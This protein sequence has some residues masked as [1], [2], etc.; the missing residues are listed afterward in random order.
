MGPFDQRIF[1]ILFSLGAVLFCTIL[2][3]QPTPSETAA[4]KL[5]ASVQ[6][7][8]A[9]I[10]LH[11]VQHPGTSSI[12]IHR[13]LKEATQWGS[14]YATVAASA[15]E[16]QDNN[17]TIG[18]SY[19]YRVHRTGGGT[20]YGY[21]NAGIEVPPM[22]YKGRIILLVDNTL[23]G[24]LAPEIGELEIDLKADGWT[25]IREDVDPSAQ[26]TAV[27]NTI[28]GHY[29][30]APDLVKAVYSV[31][32]VP[33]PYSGN[34]NPDGHSSHLGAWPCDGYYGE[35]N[36]TWT[37]NGTYQQNA[38]NPKNN[39]VPGDG[40]FDQNDFP[41]S[42]ELQVGRVDLYDMPAFSEGTVQLM[43]N[44][45]DRA[46]CFKRREWVPEARGMIFDN[47]QW[48]SDPLGA[49]GWRTLPAMVGP[50]NIE[51]PYCY[52]PP[53]HSYTQG[54][55]YLWT[56]T[57]GGGGYVWTDGQITYNSAGNIGSTEEYAGFSSV[58]GVFN[59]SLG[60]YFGDWDN[61]NNFLK[62]PLAAG[63]ALTN[64]WSGMP[65]WYFHHMALGENI[66]YSTRLSMNNASGLYAP[67][68]DGWQGG[69][70]GRTH[71][72]LMGD[73]TLRMTMVAPPTGLVINNSNGSAS[74]SWNQSPESVLG[75]YLYQFDPVTGVPARVVPDLLTGGGYSNP[76]IPFIPGR[77]YMVRAVKLEEHFSGSYYN[78]SL[79]AIAVAQ[80]G[81]G[82]LDCEGVPGGPK[83]PGTACDDGNPN[84]AN[85]TWNIDCECIGQLIDCQDVPG[86]TALPG[87]PCN[88]GNA[89]TGN[90]TWTNNC[91]CVG[92]VI[93]CQGTP[94]GAALPGTPCNDG[95]ANTINDTW[96]NNCECAGTPL[97]EDCEGTPGGAALPGTPCN[98]GNANT[99][100]DTWNDNCQCVGQ[101]I[102]C[103]GTPGGAALPGTACNDN[104]P[105]TVNDQWN[106]DCECAGTIPPTD[107]NGIPGGPAL[108]GTP[109]NDGDPT[110]GNDT[111]TTDCECV[112]N[113]LDCAGVPGGSAF[114]DDCG[115]CTGGNT[116]NEPNADTDLDGELDCADICPYAFDPAQTDY[117]GDGVGDACDNCP[118]VYNPDQADGNS[119]GFG[120]MCDELVGIAENGLSSG[121]SLYPNPSQGLVTVRVDDVNLRRLLFHDA[122]GRMVHEESYALQLDLGRL[123]AGVYVVTGIDQD[124]NALVQTRFVKQ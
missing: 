45:L 80:G 72:G 39:N 64:C 69:G 37:D 103:L 95:N 105:N 114:I 109:C 47:L 35:L 70:L 62:A 71:L 3:A 68:N 60:S 23:A 122:T 28:I 24:P 16:F 17:V 27:R 84:T 123:A 98:D 97:A 75:Y 78:L 25:V 116:G 7:N 6:S 31:G 115:E 104:N 38:S 112:G 82:A 40:K 2:A 86:G 29:N 61:R 77:E 88:D 111:W 79:G 8:P 102:D 19:E 53:F 90:D 121:F 34:V 5:Y 59:M 110:T 21:V 107:C 92:Q 119:N 85:D 30:A 94:G 117:D 57:S 99:G 22:E 13:K 54:Q 42:V 43:R 67:Q 66:G 10:T 120:N 49:S 9:R 73:P 108:P 56:Y 41:S 93:D 32:H 58:G 118:W 18:T 83:V 113:N 76:A 63:E 48:V 74:F 81:G 101:L 11:W 12:T 52:G 33:V 36:G 15:T 50:T 89:N 4:V 46:H 14:A 87:T 55:S 65:P 106:N 96:S 44:Y 20:A 1:R 51:A 91:Q 100:N 26:V 124:G